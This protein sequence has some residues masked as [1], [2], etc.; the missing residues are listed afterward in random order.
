VKNYEDGKGLMIQTEL[1]GSLDFAKF[2]ISLSN[3]RLI[4]EILMEAY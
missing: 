2:S 1:S 4:I 3:L